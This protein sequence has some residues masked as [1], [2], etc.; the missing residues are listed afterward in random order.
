[1]SLSL[2]Q[3]SKRAAE[4]RNVLNKAGHAYYVLDSPSIEDAVYDHLYRELLDI[5]KSHPQKMGTTSSSAG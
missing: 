3:L 2:T 1:M 4:L 5:E